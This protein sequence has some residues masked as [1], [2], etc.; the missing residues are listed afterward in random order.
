[1]NYLPA[2]S[3]FIA[4]I[5]T[6]FCI[7]ANAQ[8]TS[9]FSV[10]TGSLYMGD[11]TSATS[12]SSVLYEPVVSKYQFDNFAVKLTLAHQAISPQGDWT[13]DA[14][15]FHEL[16]TST[17][18]ATFALTYRLPQAAI[19]GWIVAVTAKQHASTEYQ[20]AQFASPNF[21][22]LQ[23]DFR[24]TVEAWTVFSRMGYERAH[25]LDGERAVSRAYSS[26]GSSYQINRRANI[27]VSMDYRRSAASIAAP[28][29]EANTNLSVEIGKGLHCQAYLSKG[30]SSGDRSLDLGVILNA[31]F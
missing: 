26:V 11:P 10:A 18:G 19:P 25:A 27:E 16:E 2:F 31:R 15:P 6:S 14:Y 8:T 28:E 30:L 22:A 13:T 9:G 3:R 1:M 17:G 4:T 20:K 12:P 7:A 23:F 24:R 21:H 5:L 29:A